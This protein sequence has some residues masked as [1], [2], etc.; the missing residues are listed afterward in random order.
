[1]SRL[2]TAMAS[3][4]GLQAIPDNSSLFLPSCFVQSR[5]PDGEKTYTLWSSQAAMFPFASPMT[6][7]D[8]FPSKGISRTVFPFSASRISNDAVFRSSVAPITVATLPS[9]GS[10]TDSRIHVPQFRDQTLR[11][12]S[13][14]HMLNTLAPTHSKRFPCASGDRSTG[15]FRSP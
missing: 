6:G 14:S 7:P 15:K 4:S 9:R 8:H 3:S 1:M 11:S 2:I 10:H 5:S 13:T 12:F